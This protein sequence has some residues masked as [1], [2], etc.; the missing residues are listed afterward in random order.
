MLRAACLAF[1]LIVLTPLLVYSQ[2]YN[3]L[4]DKAGLDEVKAITQ[5]IYNTNHQQAEARLALLQ[6]KVPLNHPVHPLLKAI[7]IYW[8][9]APMQAA[10]PYF[11]EFEKYVQQTIKLAENY[12]DRD[13]D[14]HVSTFC[15]LTAHSL[16]ARFYAEK[17]ETMNA[18]REARATYGYMKEG[19]D[20]KD[21]YNEFY[22]STGIFNYYRVKY[23]EQHPVYKPF[24]WFFQEG[25]KRLGLQQLEYAARNTVFTRV[26]SGSF[27]VLLYLY[28]ENQPLKALETIRPLYSKFPQNR[29]LRLQ[30]T[31]SLVAAGQ[32]DEAARHIPY[33]LDQE[34][35][36]YRFAGELFRAILAE[37]QQQNFEQ[38]FTHYSRALVIAESLPARADTYR[39]MVHAGLARYY[40]AKKQEAK[41][42][43]SWKEALK[44]A[45]YDYPVKQQAKKQLE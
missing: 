19:F 18:V 13:A 6:R 31:E 39:S 33:L 5:L 34:A 8:K 22:F 23:P 45:H 27:L 44:F 32:Y 40:E 28:N 14:K 24:M 37:K 41:A 1:V 2:A 10:S 3:L 29:Y 30:Y 21:E 11:P 35:P 15:A 38:A 9:D 42:R 43:T 12:L 4:A 16:L 26:E 17:G 36:Y 20:L 7:N 25:D